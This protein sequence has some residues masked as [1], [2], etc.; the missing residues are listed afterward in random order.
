MCYAVKAPKEAE[1][2]MF[3]LAENKDVAVIVVTERIAEAIQPVIDEVSR[4]VYPT[5]LTVPGKEGP[6]PGKVSP[7][8]SLVKKTIGV[9]IKI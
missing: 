5:V 9:E 4:R 8:M 3:K 7:I 6:I 1:D 2:L